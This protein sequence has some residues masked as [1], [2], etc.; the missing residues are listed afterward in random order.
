MPYYTLKALL[1]CNPII[2]Y[3]AFITCSY[4]SYKCFIGG[5]IIVEKYI[6]ENLKKVLTFAYNYITVCYKVL[7]TMH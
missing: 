5:G 7:W 3:S 6:N 4:P 1:V 2:C